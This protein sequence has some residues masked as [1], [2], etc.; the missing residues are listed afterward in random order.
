LDDIYSYIITFMVIYN[1]G[2]VFLFVV[3]CV[4]WQLCGLICFCVSVPKQR[5]GYVEGFLPY[6]SSS[7]LA[8]SVCHVYIIQLA[9]SYI[10]P[11]AV[12]FYSFPRA[13]L[14]QRWRSTIRHDAFQ[15]CS[16]STFR[17]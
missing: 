7:W 9:V 4:Q 1:N 13:Q 2:N 14:A 6:D 8:V 3:G 12:S 5:D 17:T 15:A 10:R 11:S 16:S